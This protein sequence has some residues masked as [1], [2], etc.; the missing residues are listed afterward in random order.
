MPSVKKKTDPSWT[1]NADVAKDKPTVV[2]QPHV[3]VAMTLEQARAAID[4]LDF[5]SRI[6]IG[7]LEEIANVIRMGEVPM[8]E[9]GQKERKIADIETCERIDLLMV[10]VKQAMGFSRNS[11]NRIGHPHNSAKCNRAYELKKVIAKAVSCRPG[12]TTPMFSVDRDGLGP[13]YTTD[14]AAQATWVEK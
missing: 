9:S 4:A 11:S 12:S 2:D 14:P 6:G 1:P 10:S 3:L 5:F 7:Q 8:N 13:R